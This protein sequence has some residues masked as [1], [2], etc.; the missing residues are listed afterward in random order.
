[1]PDLGDL[2]KSLV[3]DN[4]VKMAITRL[5]SFLPGF[6]VGGPIGLF[7]RPIITG[8]IVKFTDQLYE[9]LR[10]TINFQMIVFK[11]EDL[12]R[13]Y[14]EAGVELASIANEKGIDSPEFAEARKANDE[15]FY[16]FVEYQF[17]AG[18]VA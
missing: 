9:F 4:I 10:L 2:F 8:F 5:F 3:W 14:T 17:S 16:D 15:A 11:V 6:L 12:E 1:M 13:K 18:R 7:L